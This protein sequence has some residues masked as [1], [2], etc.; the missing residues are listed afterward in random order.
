M[1]VRCRRSRL[2]TEP[3]DDTRPVLVVGASLGGLRIAE[4]LRRNGFA[5][6]LTVMGAEA[7]LP[8]NRPPLSKAALLEGVDHAG[9]AFPRRSSLDDVEWLLGSVAES[10]SFEQQYVHALDGSRRD[11]RALVVAT[12]VRPRRL[13][14]DTGTATG[15]H[16]LRTLDDAASLRAA[17]MPGALVVVVGSGF[18]GCEVAATAVARGCHVTV[19]SD[20]ALPMQRPLGALLAAELMR[21]H[22]GHGV[23]FRMSVRVE[24]LEVTDGRVTAVLLGDGS[25]LPCDVVVEA[26]GSVPNTEWLEGNDLDRDHG[27]RTDSGLRVLRRDGTPWPT[28]FAV[29]DVARFPNEAFGGG[30]YAIEHWNIPTETGRRAGA[31]LAASLTSPQ[32]LPEVL[33]ARFAPMPSFWSDQYDVHLLSIGMLGLATRVELLEGRLADE[34]VVGYF[35]GDRLVGV[36]GIGMAAEVQRLRSGIGIAPLHEGTAR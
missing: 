19:V 33:A 25:K 28:V 13:P 10:A 18:I 7:H 11:Y 26:L 31:V 36:C 15:R 17:L 34:C 27:I 22:E 8:Y 12:G 16:V 2:S 20:V 29:G 32:T 6:P 5:G 23:V 30:E 1:S 4:S 24:R 14:I 3:P 35:Q 9:L 21:R